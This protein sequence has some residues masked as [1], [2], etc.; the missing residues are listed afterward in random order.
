M[1]KWDLSQA[2]KVDLTFKNQYIGSSTNNAPFYYKI[3]CY[4]IINMQFH[5][6]TISHSSTPYNIR[7]NV[8][9]KTINNYTHIITLPTTLKQALLLPDPVYNS[10]YIN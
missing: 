8:Q 1:T 7:L 3:L 10:L 9:I 5:N 4:K 6:I 2:H